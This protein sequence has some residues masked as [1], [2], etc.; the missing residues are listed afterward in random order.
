[1]PEAAKEFINAASG[2]ATFTLATLVLFVLM[3]YFYRTWTKPKYAVIPPILYLI[4]MGLSV[5]IP[6][7]VE[8]DPNFQKLIFKADN[9]P[10]IMLQIMLYF[11]LWLSLRQAAIN[12]ERIENGLPPVEKTESDVKVFCWPDLVYVELITAVLITVGLIVWSILIKAPLE[13]PASAT[14]APNPSKAPWYFLGLQE[15][16]VYFDP[17]MAGVVLPTL[18]I[19]GLIAIPYIDKNP[20]G[21][22]YYTV[23]QR[24]FAITIFLLGFLVFWMSYIQMGTFLRGPNWNFFGPYEQ[25]TVTKT[26]SLQNVDFAQIFWLDIL[27]RSY[28]PEAWYIR[29]MPGMITV[30][31]YMFG[32]P[33]LLTFVVP[34]FRKLYRQLGFI[35]HNI[36]MFLLLVMF[37]IPIKMILRWT[38][39]LK[40]IVHIKEYFINI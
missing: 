38:L 35:R 26:P 12:D 8:G 20:K 13:A 6:G 27:G 36:M 9:V 2:P 34:F 21:K 15:L 5:G 40:Y 10:I 4:F 7:V 3:M 30:V 24:P 31:L 23:K 22:G 28:L 32:L 1:M 11:F 25:W 17:W 18:I 29:E 14:H 19:V 37:S 16:L 33:P 39:N